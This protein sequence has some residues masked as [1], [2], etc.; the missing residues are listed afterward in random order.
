M[1]HYLF[2]NDL[3]ISN[4]ETV[5]IEAAKCFENDCVPSASE[6]KNANNNMN[7]LGFYFNLTKD[8]N[9]TK[10]CVNGNVRKV[11]LNFI[12][13]FQFPNPRTTASLRDC[14]DDSIELAPMRVILK[15]LYLMTMICPEQAYLTNREIAD[16]IFFNANI[17]KNAKPDIVATIKEIISCRVGGDNSAIPDDAVLESNGFFWKQCRRQVREMVKVLCWSGCVTEEN[18]E[19]RIH[20]DNL[21]RDNEADL[22]EILTFNEFWEPDAKR[23]AEENKESYQEYMDVYSV[24]ALN[25]Q[26]SYDDILSHNLYGMHIKLENDALSDDRPHICIG[27]SKMGDLGSISSKADLDNKYYATW[28]N[29]KPK[30]K[31]QDSGQIWRF[32]KEVNVGD[33][34]IFSDGPFCHIGKV[35]SG[36]YYDNKKYEHQDPDYTNVRNVIWLRKNIKRSE[37]SSNLQGSLGTGMSIWRMNDYKSVVVDLLKG[38]YSKD[39]EGKENPMGETGNLIYSTGILKD[40]SRNK[41]IFGAPGT[42]KSFTVNQER[43]KLLGSDNETNYERVTFHPDYSYANFVGT[44]KPVMINDKDNSQLDPDVKYVISV[45]N[46]KNKTAQEKY[47]LLYDKF[48]DNGLTRLPV[49]LGLY[50]D[51]PFKT[52]QKDGSATADDNSVG[53]NHGRAIRKY[54]ELITEKER[55]SDIAYEYVPG[56]FMRVYVNALKSARTDN[57]KPYL[58]I[59]EE[60]NRANV[61][62]VFGDIFQL[63]DRGDDGVSEYP[64][65]ASEDIKKYLAKELGGVPEDYSK[66]RI[67]DNMFIWA[68]MNSADQGV[69]PMDTAFKRRW[70]FTYLGIDDNDKDIRGKYVVLGKGQQRIEWNELRKAIN[71]FLADNKINEDKQLGPY[72]IARSIVVPSDG[73]SEINSEKFCDV[74]KNK[75]LMYLFDDAAKQKR[76]KIFEGSLKG[77]NR[78]SMICEA[79]DEQ[80]IGIFSQDIKSKVTIHSSKETSIS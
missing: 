35:E 59:I 60:I 26:A 78:Y 29:A 38:T 28:P 33:Y 42:G 79:F 16:F 44:Y 75:V 6:D 43:I 46:D 47:D 67:P 27:W 22:F 12:K 18:G 76:A 5:L 19:I 24:E 31:G 73:G 80:G 49:L 40:A 13:K 25:S 65:Q 1:F 69:F 32:L 53:R 9:C 68:T 30:A 10:E 2:T 4:L 7:T 66:I 63:L 52:R 8:S 56:P 61:A 20:H 55:G 23:N 54:V 41:I 21:S 39:D 71:E 72:F 37:L 3:R 51:D 15:M 70:D 17:A 48:K 14:I 45:L 36:Y 11:V 57:P 62:A 58:L 64:I 34:V 74:F 50:T 77:Q